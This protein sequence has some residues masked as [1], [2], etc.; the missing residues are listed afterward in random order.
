MKDHV[1]VKTMAIYHPRWETSGE[2]NSANTLISA[3]WHLKL[4]GNKFFCLS[5]KKK[6]IRTHIYTEGRPYEDTRENQS[7]ISQGERPQNLPKLISDFHSPELWENKFL[8]LKPPSLWSFVN[9]PLQT[10]TTSILQTS[11]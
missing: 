10:S 6:K 11:I 2:T 4:W 9:R 5:Q 7:S 1:N 8:L 3:F